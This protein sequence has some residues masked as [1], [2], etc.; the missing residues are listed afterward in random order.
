[1]KNQSFC[2]N[3]DNRISSYFNFLESRNL[4]IEIGIKAYIEKK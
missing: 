4:I 3:S 2:K 1:M